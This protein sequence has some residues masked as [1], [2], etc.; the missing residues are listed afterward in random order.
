MTTHSTVPGFRFDLN[1]AR[2]LAV[3]L[4]V[5]YHI[6]PEYI[7]GGYVGVD[8]FFVISGYL[9]SKHLISEIDKNGKISFS[10]FAKKR[11]IRLFPAA[12]IVLVFCALLLT[13]TNIIGDPRSNYEQLQF[14]AL[15]AQ[16]WILLFDSVDYLSVDAAPTLIR[17]YWSLSVEWQLY[18][19]WPFLLS[20]TVYMSKYAMNKNWLALLFFSIAI[21]GTG[22]AC[23]SIYAS[24]YAENYDAYFSLFSRIWEFAVGG[25]CYIASL[26]R[27]DSQ[28]IFSNITNKFMPLIGTLLIV[29]SAAAFSSNTIFPGYA[30]FIPVSG[31]ILVIMTKETEKITVYDKFVSSKVLQYIGS[32]SYSL[33]LWHWP[34]LVIYSR[35]FMG[36]HYEASLLDG[37]LVI[38]VSVLF[39][40]LTYQFIEQKAYL[41]RKFRPKLIILSY[42]FLTLAYVMSI[43]VIPKFFEKVQR[44]DIYIFKTVLE[45]Q[46][47]IDK[48][49]ARY[50]WPET[51]LQEGKG[52]QV[53]EWVEDACNTVFLKDFLIDKKCIYGSADAAKTL[54]LVGDSWATHFLTPLKNAISNDWKIVTLTVSQCPF[55]EVAVHE[56]GKKIEFE[57]C[58]ENRQSLLQWLKKNP[59]TAIVVSDSSHSTYQRLL[60]GNKGEVAINEIVSG[61]EYTYSQLAPLKTKLVHLASPPRANCTSR[62]T[63][64]SN[65][66][67]LEYT[68]IQRR[69]SEAKMRVALKSGFNIVDTL[70]WGCDEKLICP[71]QIDGYLVKADNGHFSRNYAYRI[72]GLMRAELEKIGIQ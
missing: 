46:S 59:P 17:H 13:T 2:A 61:L 30:A 1:A 44:N 72:S 14:S 34:V 60:S 55:A 67:S 10:G 50:T 43:F 37:V 20:I 38:A 15:N 42:F 29:F 45:I 27:I 66:E 22:S 41:L 28:S 51:D 70:L 4:V 57:S 6:W 12:F 69:I 11:I 23:Y 16:N 26:Y 7:P 39:A 54:V 48:T 49:L 8:I 9:I 21:V 58:S 3:A 64:P 56:W 33:Y 71:Y 36:G 5:L 68:R 65:C 32:I 25:I 62:T 63:N 40:A 52:A 53:T 24:Y 18:A 35:V 19:L 31:I 47:R